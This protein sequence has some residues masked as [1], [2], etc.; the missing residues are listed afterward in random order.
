VLGC[1][2]I[3]PTDNGSTALSLLVPI[4]LMKAAL[5][6]N[7][8]AW[9]LQLQTFWNVQFSFILIVMTNCRLLHWKCWQ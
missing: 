6:A 7:T 9:I 8:F 4:Q 3:I 5:S 1:L 2:L